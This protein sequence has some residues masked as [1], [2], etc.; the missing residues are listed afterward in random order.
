MH[1]SLCING[2]KFPLLTSRTEQEVGG[3]Y[4][5]GFMV[6]V[7]EYPNGVQKLAASLLAL[8]QMTS[9]EQYYRP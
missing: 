7:L 9:K 3:L 4:S 6:V 8:L 5:S 2:I 1:F